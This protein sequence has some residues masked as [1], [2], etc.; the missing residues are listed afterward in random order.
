[1]AFWVP[2]LLVAAGLCL[3]VAV[4]SWRRRP[5][6]G[7]LG[8][9]LL[10][11]SMTAWALIYA[12]QW[13]FTDHSP[14]L[15]WMVAR[16][17]FIKA[18]PMALLLL[19]VD[20][21]GRANWFTRRNL[22]LFLI[23]PVITLLIL[24]TDPLHHLYLGGVAP[25]L[26][27]LTGGPWLWVNLVYSYVLEAAAL[28]LLI[29]H[30]RRHKAQRQQTLILMVATLLPAVYFLIELTDFHIF[31]EVNATPLSFVLAGLMLSFGLFRVG[32][33]KVIPIARD[34]LV[35]EMPDGVVVFDADRRIIDINPAALRLASGTKSAL[36]RTSEE[37]F[38]DQLDTIHALRAGLAESGY[39]QHQSWWDAEHLV[40]ATATAIADRSGDPVAFLVILRDITERSALAA[41]LQDRSEKLAATQERSG[42]V[43]AAMSEGVLLVDS[44]CRLLRSNPAAARILERELEGLEGKAMCDLVSVIPTIE[45]TYRASV[46]NEPITEIMRLPDGRAL[47]VEVTA[48]REAEESGQTLFVIRDET[49]RLAAERMQREFVAN[50]S[51]ELQTPLTGLTLLSE[52]LPHAARE[53]PDQVGAFI[54]RMSSE[55][56]RITRLTSEL[57]TLSRVDQVTTES[58]MCDLDFSAIA[59][60]ELAGATSLA[61]AKDHTLAAQIAPDLYVC[62]DEIGLRAIVSNML[63]NAIRYTD[64][65]GDVAVTLSCERDTDDRGWAVLSVTDS[66]I[67]ISPEDVEHVFERFFRVDKARS[68]NTGGAGLGLSIV[69][70]ATEQHGGSVTVASDPGLGSTFTVRIP[71]AE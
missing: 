58:L 1:M 33:L 64:D 21:T 60:E 48:L 14:S 31:H 69:R 29:G 32:M 23:E 15:T 28:A 16:L 45:L 27:V 20:Y 44:E 2:S 63:M 25:A 4:T 22:V 56:G 46:S 70:H 43:L 67:G 71:L 49:E 57:M 34:R 39:G 3:T 24:I 26:R 8:L 54:E 10:C 37:V 13:Q 36:G 51:H 19:V 52:T 35:E 50:V 68:R 59:S 5:A 55:V 18:A 30:Y 65:G 61:G 9:A 66:G 38:P 12:A 17:I 41:Q 62:G 6:P 47:T 53:N 7:A 11:G 40:E 42:L